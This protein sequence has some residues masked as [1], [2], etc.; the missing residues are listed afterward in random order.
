MKK[1]D[2]TG[3]FFF[4]EK[5]EGIKKQSILTHLNPES[6]SQMQIPFKNR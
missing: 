6:K 5:S 2:P 3:F 1:D 4:T